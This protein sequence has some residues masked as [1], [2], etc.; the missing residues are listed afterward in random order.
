MKCSIA[1]SYFLKLQS[2]CLLFFSVVADLGT[3]WGLVTNTEPHG[4]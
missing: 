1:I 3:L 4:L 2:L